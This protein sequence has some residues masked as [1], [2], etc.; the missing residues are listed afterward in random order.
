[1]RTTIAERLARRLTPKEH[2]F[3]LAYVQ[4]GEVGRAARAA[5]YGATATADLDRLLS[6]PDVQAEV[7]RQFELASSEVAADRS[8][9][10]RA[11]LDVAGAGMS[12]FLRIDESGQ[13][14]VD[15]S[16]TLPEQL[17]AIQ[18]LRVDERVTPDGTVLRRTTIKLYDRLKAIELLAKMIGAFAP[19][20]LAV[21]AAPSAD[22]L[23]DLS[24]EDAARAYKA[25]LEAPKG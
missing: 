22:A 13:G 4:H 2:R 10:I 11:L 16:E 14:Y 25:M 5:G 1:M 12:Q 23:A 9:L 17:D 3:V 19:D 15:L 21:V 8:R 24:P 18:D 20:K 6:D 7:I